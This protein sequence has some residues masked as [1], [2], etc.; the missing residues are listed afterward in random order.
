MTTPAIQTRPSCGTALVWA[1]LV[2]AFGAPGL[3]VAA[4]P[5]ASF[6]PLRTVG[7]QGVPPLAPS[8]SSIATA[9]F[10]N[11][12]KLDLV[13]GDSRSFAVFLGDGNGNFALSFRPLFGAAFFSGPRAVAVGDFNGD[14]NADVALAFSLDLVNNDPTNIV[15]FLGD[16]SGRFTELSNQA[17]VVGGRGHP[18]LAAG[19]FDGDGIL[20]LAVADSV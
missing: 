11:D 2:L 14:G 7:G 18:I 4:C 16:G 15:I 1:L 5:S 6:Q 20:D 10:N 3:A 13:V 8:P 12:G 9:D 17:I 19:D